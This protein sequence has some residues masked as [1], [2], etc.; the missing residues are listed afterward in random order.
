MVVPGACAAQLQISHCL[1]H[2]AK[3]SHNQKPEYGTPVPRTCLLPAALWFSMGFSLL[4]IGL[5]TV[6]T[7]CIISLVEYL[8][9]PI[10]EPAPTGFLLFMGLSR[11]RPKALITFH[12]LILYAITSSLWKTQ[13]IVCDFF[14]S[15]ITGSFPQLHI[16]A[17]RLPKTVSAGTL[18]TP[19]RYLVVRQNNS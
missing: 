2:L 5:T 14:K 3:P 13:D 6:I 4:K 7:P 10:R 1:Y 18:D 16:V 19:Y 8:I 9:F 12:P 17:R 15:T 11:L